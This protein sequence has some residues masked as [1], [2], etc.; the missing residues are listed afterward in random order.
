[1]R[2]TSVVARESASKKAN[3]DIRGGGRQRRGGVGCADARHNGVGV[4]PL[5][6]A[7]RGGF[8][9]SKSFLLKV[10][11]VRDSTYP[12]A[13]PPSW[14]GDGGVK[15]VGGACVLEGSGEEVA[16]RATGGGNGRHAEKTAAEPR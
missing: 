16:D 15:C 10:D 3:V 6:R 4:E 12:I 1:M 5:G 7:S 8:L 13:A 11:N 2:P 14:E 9:G